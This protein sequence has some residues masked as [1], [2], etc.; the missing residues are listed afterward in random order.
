MT[1]KHIPVLL[2]ECIDGLNIKSNGIYVDCTVGGGG[3]SFFIAQKIF[4]GQKSKLIC[5]DRDQYA[6]SAAKK[7]LVDFSKKI[8]FIHD[9]FCHIKKIAAENQINKVDGILLDLGVSSFQLDIAER[10]FSYMKNANLDMRMDQ[11]QKLTAFDLV[12]KSDIKELSFI[13]KT[14]GEEKF[15]KQIANKIC[16][17]RKKKPIKTTLEL[18]EAIR[19]TVPKKY[20][21]KNHPEKKTFQAIRIAVNNEIQILEQTLRDCID[22][23]NTDGRLCV[24]SFHSLEDRMVKNI[25]KDTAIGCICPKEFPIC[26]CNKKPVCEIITK[27]PI[28]ATELEIKNNSRS[29]SAKLRIIKKI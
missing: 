10:G 4:N 13:I 8:I 20:L 6:L 23:L 5:I 21:Y 22:L 15:Y 29:H 11:S 2:K 12:N 26:I 19:S 24:I 17:L 25:F 27:R 16:F 18:V 9:N 1:L 14:Y 28:C 7:K 3:H